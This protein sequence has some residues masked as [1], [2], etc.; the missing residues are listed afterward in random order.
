MYFATPHSPRRVEAPLPGRGEKDEEQLKKSVANHRGAQFYSSAVP[1]AEARVKAPTGPLHSSPGRRIQVPA[2]TGISAP[3]MDRA[4][5][6][7]RKA[8]V[9]PTSRG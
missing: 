8:T 7:A 3:V 4:S 9:R 5:S 6:L 1:S 2:S